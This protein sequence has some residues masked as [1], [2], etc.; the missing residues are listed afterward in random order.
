MI[1]F[2]QTNRPLRPDDPEIITLRIKCQDR[3]RLVEERTAKLNELRAILK[4]HYPAFLGLFSDIKSQISLE[5]L[6]KFPTQKQ[7]QKLTQ[8]RF[9]TWQTD[10]L[11]IIYL[12][13]LI[14]FP[15]KMVL[16]FLSYLLE[17]GKS[18]KNLLSLQ[19]RLIRLSENL[20]YSILKLLL[21]QKKAYLIAF[22]ALL[23]YHSELMLVM[24][25]FYQKI[26]TILH[27]QSQ[28]HKF[29]LLLY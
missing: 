8:R 28:S 29:L 6:E 17:I 1:T 27:H 14:A 5:F 22:I 16:K 12:I 7:M 25:I 20:I 13:G 15:T 4:G 26:L 9:L 2:H 21:L 3:L 23:A 18:L 19:M 10:N 11:L 24:N